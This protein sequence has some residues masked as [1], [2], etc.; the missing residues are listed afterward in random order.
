VIARDEA[1]ATNIHMADVNGDGVTDF[2]ASRGHAAG[3]VWYQGPNWQRHMIYPAIEG[4]HSLVVQDLDGDGDIDAATCGKDN[5]Q[6]AW[7]ENDGSGNFQT[8]LIGENQAAYDMQAV[9]MDGD[10]DLDFLIAG[11]LSLNVVWYENPAGASN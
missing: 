4:P 10:G 3:I 2:I 9:D 7:F 11:Q 8:H 5:Q 1:G 6:V